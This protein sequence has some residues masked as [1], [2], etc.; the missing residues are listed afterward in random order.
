MK[1]FVLAAGESR[2][3]LPL[4]D[5][6]PKPMLQI[7][8]R[9]I[10]E[11]NIRLLAAYGVQDIAINL[12][13]CPE[14][15][16]QHFGDGS[17]FGVSIRYS[18]EASLLGTAGAL[19]P[20]QD[21]FT[22]SL[23]LL[24]G[25]NLSTC[26]LHRLLA[27]HRQQHSLATIAVFQRADVAS[28]GVVG[29]GPDGR[30]HRFVEKPKPSEVSGNW[31][32]AGIAVLEPAVIDLIPAGVPSDF[33]RDVFPSLLERGEPLYAYPMTERLWWIDSP[34]DYARTLSEADEIEALIN[35]PGGLGW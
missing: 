28:S 14:V 13:H 15:V 27:R 24:Y 33:G 4:T 17:R 32:N 21:R 20:L 2:R 31:V 29:F 12:H 5:R 30:V 11:H 18:Y 9:P 16:R 8:K 1:A 25:D 19:K 23:F 10:L 35:D 26:N 22:E 6:I 3:L 7:G 34:A